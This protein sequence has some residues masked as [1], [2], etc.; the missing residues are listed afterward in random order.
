MG[1]VTTNGPIGLV[2]LFFPSSF[3]LLIPPYFLLCNEN[4]E[5]ERERKSSRK[6][7][8][9]SEIKERKSDDENK[10]LLAITGLMT[11][12]KLASCTYHI[13]S[14]RMYNSFY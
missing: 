6:E 7:G 3:D 13:P 9:K 10:T 8:R 12:P 14:Y 5:R 1:S 4:N 11:I 2:K